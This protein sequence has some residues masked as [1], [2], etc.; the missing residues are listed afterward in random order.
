MFRR[1]KPK[2]GLIV[3]I[4]AAAALAA[5]GA[6]SLGKLFLVIINQGNVPGG[7]RVTTDNSKSVVAREEQK[8]FLLNPVP[9]YFL[10]AGVY[11]T[12]ESAAEAAK[13]L[14]KA[15]YMPYIT[16][17][18]PHKI[19]LGIYE[20]RFG[21]EVIKQQ[22]RDRGI[23]SFTASVVVNGANLRYGQGSEGFIKEIAPLL[24]VYTTWLKDN[25][26]LFHAADAGQLNWNAVEKQESVIEKVYGEIIRL[27]EGFSTNNEEVN[28]KFKVLRTTVE[29]Y[30]RLLDGFL[31]QRDRAGYFRLQN[32][33]LSFIDSYQ[34]IWKEIDNVSKT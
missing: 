32:K 26:P 13:Q 16:Q 4:I 30:H 3:C 20:Q 24:E 9:V 6:Y 7:K 23:G 28:S 18:Q 12:P 22:L 17:S 8:L 33:L 14:E 5:G 1:F 19:W 29:E 2:I 10:Q 34:E 27:D 21:T 15:G 25:L 31:D 11:S